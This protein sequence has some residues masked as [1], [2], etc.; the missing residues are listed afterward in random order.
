MTAQGV[1]LLDLGKG[2]E[3]YKKRL[4]NGEIG[5]LRGSVACYARVASVDRVRR[6]P[7]ERAIEAVRGSPRLCRVAEN[8]LRRVGALRVRTVRLR[9]P[10]AS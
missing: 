9:A 7:Q 10:G 6:W 1:S 4:S 2:H 3:A 8:G 5:L